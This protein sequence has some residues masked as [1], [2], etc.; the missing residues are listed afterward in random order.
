GRHSRRRI[1]VDQ[2]RVP[3]DR[4]FAGRTRR[5]AR[6]APDSHRKPGWHDQQAVQM[7]SLELLPKSVSGDL[8]LLVTGRSRQSLQWIAENASGW[9]MY[10]QPVAQQT[11]VLAS[12]RETLQQAQQAWK[13]FAQS[14]YVDL[15]EQPDASPSPIHLGYR[16]GRNRLTE[17]LS[18]LRSIGVNHVAINLR[19]SSRPVAEV[20]D[21]IAQYVLP[22]FHRKLTANT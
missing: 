3:L 17:H 1:L 14:L 9:L 13:P 2:H 11:Q 19:F 12:W 6:L 20:I 21:E 7:G 10:P 22:E 16:L 8:P 4:T 15:A 18:A 5:R